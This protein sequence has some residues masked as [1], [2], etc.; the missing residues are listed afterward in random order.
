MESQ[1]ILPEAIDE[2]LNSL[3]SLITKGF[4]L[5]EGIAVGPTAPGQKACDRLGG[6]FSFLDPKKD[7]VGEN[8][9]DKPMGIAHAQEAFPGVVHYSI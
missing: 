7:S 6:E 3:V 8:R 1:R 5:A 2:V 9:I 4:V